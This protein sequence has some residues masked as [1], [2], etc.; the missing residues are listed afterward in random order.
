MLDYRVIR[1]NLLPLYALPLCGVFLF[2]RAD[3]LKDLPISLAARRYLVR[4]QQ[5]DLPVPKI[6]WE[7]WMLG[8]HAA[9]NASDRPVAAELGN[10]SESGLSSGK[11]PSLGRICSGFPIASQ[12][13]GHDRWVAGVLITKPEVFLAEG[14]LPEVHLD[15]SADLNPV[16]QG[17]NVTG[18]G[19]RLDNACEANPALVG[20]IGYFQYLHQLWVLSDDPQ[21]LRN[22][23]V[24]AEDGAVSCAALDFRNLVVQGDKQDDCGEDSSFLIGRDAFAQGEP[25]VSIAG[26]E[27]DLLPCSILQDAEQSG[28]FGLGVNLQLHLYLV[29]VAI[30][31]LKRQ[32]ESAGYFGTRIY[33]TDGLCAL[34]KKLCIHNF[35]CTAFMVW[36]AA[37]G[38]RVPKEPAQLF[39]H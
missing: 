29:A 37:D 23:F 2:E 19:S 35:C 34:D 39:I 20:R 7:I 32:L 25:V 26:V 13:V 14:F 12:V 24:S 3:S 17:D 11:Y 10:N 1:P 8:L 33:E 6:G 27:D 18:G 31:A 21:I 15:P 5:P 22:F 16:I 38:S 4:T 28:D 36:A 9:D 30:A